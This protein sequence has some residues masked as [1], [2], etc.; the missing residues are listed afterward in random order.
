MEIN[1]KVEIFAAIDYPDCCTLEISQINSF[2]YFTSDFGVHVFSQRSEDSEHIQTITEG[3][4]DTITCSGISIYDTCLYV[5]CVSQSGIKYIKIFTLEGFFVTSIQTLNKASWYQDSVGVLVDSA[6][7]EL[8]IFI[9]EPWGDNVHCI[10][11]SCNYTLGTF[12]NPL[13]IKSGSFELFILLKKT[14]CIAMVDKFDIC[15]TLTII[16]LGLGNMLRPRYY[17][18]RPFNFFD[19]HPRRQELCLVDPVEGTLLVYDWDGCLIEE[20]YS[21]FLIQDKYNIPHGMTF[22]EFGYVYVLMGNCVI[23]FDMRRGQSRN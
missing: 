7:G 11:E 17:P 9:C 19:I 1:R 21:D 2:M 22:D 12:Y 10:T 8:A 5:S 13:D 16:V 3:L 20:V 6:E 23:R 14:C 15:T 18:S 4:E